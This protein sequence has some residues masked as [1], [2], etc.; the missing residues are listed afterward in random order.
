MLSP[1][2]DNAPITMTSREIAELVS[3]RH[4]S[5]KRTIQ[6]LAKDGIIE[7]PPSVK[8]KDNQSLS[9][10]CFSDA[11]VFEGE[12]GKRDSIVVVAQLSSA[13]TAKLVDRW[14]ELEALTVKKVKPLTQLEML[15]QIVTE[16]AKQE[17]KLLAL[18]ETVHSVEVKIDRIEKGTLPVGFQGYSYLMAKTGM[19]RD[20]CKR[21]VEAFS[22]EHKTI[23]HFTPGGQVTDMTIVNEH[24]FMENF[25]HVVA[26]AELSGYFHHHPVLGKFK[27][28]EVRV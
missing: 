22:I 2:N 16:A 24:Q 13:F 1:F 23:P 18:S 11:Y 15:V 4:D 27:L 12:K 25:S 7:L 26:S 8:V 10:N 14:Q 6:R 5:V 19:S 28:S 20:K 3:S 9:P 21:L 17:R